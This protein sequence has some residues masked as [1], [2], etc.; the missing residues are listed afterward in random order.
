MKL[1]AFFIS[2]G[3][4][5]AANSL[6]QNTSDNT[7]YKA[8]DSTSQRMEA[9]KRMQ[10]GLQVGT[11]VS[12]N[13]RGG[14]GFHTFVSPYLSYRVSPRWSFQAGATLVNGSFPSYY[15]YSGDSRSGVGNQQRTF[16]FAQGQYQATERLRL[17]GT[18]YYE[19]L[20]QPGARQQRGVSFNSQAMALYAEY[21]I[22]EHFSVGV[23]AQYS[24]GNMPYYGNGFNGARFGRS[25]GAPGYPG[26]GYSG[27]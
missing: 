20:T 3:V 6:A 12:T 25:F 5:L 21:K 7:Y 24:N 19:M 17:T 9:P 1:S 15:P 26:L 27:W 11:G 23:G 13:F 8:P 4:L 10:F 16:L 18:T 2:I 22:S 14:T